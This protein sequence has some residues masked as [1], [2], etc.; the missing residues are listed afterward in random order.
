MKRTLW[1]LA[2]ILIS[3]GT[4]FA[5]QTFYF[6]QIADGKDPAPQNTHWHTTIFLSN[7]G[8]SLVSGTVTFFQS[9]GSAMNIPFVD[10]RGIA[11]AVGNQITFQIAAGQSRKYTSVA[12][13]NLQ[14]GYAVVNSNGQISGNAM[15]AHWISPPN[16]SLIAE[17]GVPSAALLARQAVFAD[18]Q[19]GYYTGVAVA[20]PGTSA[21]VIN[22]ELVNN[23]G[24]AVATRTL[25][26]GP[27]EHIARLHHELFNNVT[28][29]QMAGRIQF[30]SS[31]G[32]LT[33]VA[34]RFNA[35]LEKFTTLFPFTVP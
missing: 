1:V 4:G 18:T 11:A 25:T 7:Q 28:V 31:A 23:D 3:V 12:S 2:W 15:F 8:T 6:P 32:L 14:V 9:N 22:F 13:G 20:N 33:A 34:L 21:L 29:P 5:Q 35:S 27:G 19:F 30:S 17:A 24:V 26:L 10:D 16:E